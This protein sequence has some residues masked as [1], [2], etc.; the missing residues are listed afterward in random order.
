MCA[1]SRDVCERERVHDAWKYRLRFAWRVLFFFSPGAYD[2]NK[3]WTTCLRMHTLKDL[4]ALFNVGTRGCY[5]GID[6]KL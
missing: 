5:G 2:D 6:A 1:Y 4:L 3:G